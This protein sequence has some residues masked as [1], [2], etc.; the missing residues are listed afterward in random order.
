MN[1]RELVDSLAAL[2]G[3]RP[4]TTTTEG[5]D[6]GALVNG[7]E[8]ALASSASERALRAAWRRRTGGGA[9][10]L[11]LLAD[12]PGVEG[13]VLAVGPVTHDGPVRVVSAAALAD[14]LRRSVTLPALQAVRDLAEQL[15]HLDQTGV[16]GLTV[17]GLG[18]EH[19]F[20]ERLR[21][22][23]DWPE[24]ARLA[25]PIVGTWRDALRAAGYELEELR[26]GYLAR[27]DGAPVAVVH[28]VADVSAFAKLD[29]E[30][31]PPKGLLLETC[32]TTNARYGILAAGSRLRLFEAAPESGSAIA[33]YLELDTQA[34]A[35]E[36]RP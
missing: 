3:V 9:T 5:V 21:Q 36:D 19:L 11:L 31:R 23:A 35:E 27:C 10:P 15:D 33:R 4:V 20:R 1:A 13:V 8:I 17:K 32:R 25:E 34:L 16:A 2:P 7:V 26:R 29:A 6:G 22:T 28:P 30:G 12:D 14:V 18:T 24:L